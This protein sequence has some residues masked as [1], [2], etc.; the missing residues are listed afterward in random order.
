MARIFCLS[1]FLFQLS[2]TTTFQLILTEVIVEEPKVES[3]I[4]YIAAFA[5]VL[6]EYL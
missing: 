6:V 1:N 2:T 5:F 4:T 3:T